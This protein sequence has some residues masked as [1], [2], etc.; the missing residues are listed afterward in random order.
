MSRALG[1]TIIICLV[2][3]MG[4]HPGSLVGLLHHFLGVAQ[5]AGSEL[6][7]FVSKL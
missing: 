2:V 1:W 5:R 7:T 3:L 6:S 4:T